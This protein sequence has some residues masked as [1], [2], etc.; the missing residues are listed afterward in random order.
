MLEQL[1][2]KQIARTSAYYMASCKHL[3]MSVKRFCVCVTGL[4]NDHHLHK[5]NAYVENES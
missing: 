3:G 1:S 5:I 2:Q 4:W